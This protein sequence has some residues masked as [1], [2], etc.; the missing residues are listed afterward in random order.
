MTDH[1]AVLRDMRARTE[2]RLREAQGRSESDP[3]REQIAAIDHAI[4]AIEQRDALVARLGEADA[5]LAE[6]SRNGWGRNTMFDIAKKTPLLERIDGYLARVVKES[7]AIQQ[8][9]G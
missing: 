6:V 1:L 2:Y 7:G 9:A 3:I 8:E 5:L 4:A